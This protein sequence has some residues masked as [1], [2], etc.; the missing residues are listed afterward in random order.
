MIWVLLP[1]VLIILV[2]VSSPSPVIKRIESV[3]KTIG[4][5]N[6][7]FTMYDVIHRRYGLHQIQVVLGRDKQVERL[8]VDNKLIWHVDYPVSLDFTVN[9]YSVYKCL[10][11]FEHDI[12][13]E[14]KIT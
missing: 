11:R 5:Y 4:K 14:H 2:L 7:H 1:I 13:D 12:I 3:Y 10:K 9:N 8:Y 6:D